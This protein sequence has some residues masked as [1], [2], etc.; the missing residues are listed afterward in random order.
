MNHPLK[1]VLFIATIYTFSSQCSQIIIRKARLEDL[2]QIA[3]LKQ[4][5]A[6]NDFENI[7][8]NG[9]PNSPIAQ[10]PELLHE[11][12]NSVTSRLYEL[13][14]E[15]LSSKSS[16][17][18]Y[19]L[20]A[21]NNQNPDDIVGLCFSQRQ[22]TQAYIRFMAVA[23]NSRRK[24]VGSELVT[25]TISMYANV[26]SCA[27]KTFSHANKKTHAFYEKCGFTSDKK[28]VNLVTKHSAHADT[29]TFVSYQLNLKK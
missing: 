8:I 15:E 10:S 24:G 22:D 4:E 17:E 1:M 11:Y 25:K 16:T 2:P 9:Y 6:K 13:F 14:K 27:L 21:V 28:L 7:I 19:L 5:A 26:D 29:I 20:V 3:A 12:L 23:E 18:Q